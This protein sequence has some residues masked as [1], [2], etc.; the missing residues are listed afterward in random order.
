MQALAFKCAGFI[1]LRAGEPSM[2]PATHEK[3]SSPYNLLKR[4]MTTDLVALVYGSPEQRGQISAL[5]TGTA[6]SS[7]AVLAVLRQLVQHRVGVFEIDCDASMKAS[8]G[9]AARW[10]KGD[11]H[12]TCV[13]QDLIE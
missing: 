5:D 13:G 9:G 4:H 10:E 7:T 2:K 6:T 12:D 8:L 3:S 1:E 11:R